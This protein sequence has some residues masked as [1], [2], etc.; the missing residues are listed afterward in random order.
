[1]A[2]SLKGF[3]YDVE[4]KK[5]FKILPHHQAPSGVKYS[6]EALKQD[7]KLKKVVSGSFYCDRPAQRCRA[8]GILRYSSCT[9]F[10]NFDHPIVVYT[11]SDASLAHYLVAPLPISSKFIHYAVILLDI[12]IS[13]TLL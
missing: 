8:F 12:N 7:T 6:K 13:F 5:Y 9:F 4:K 3:Y 1:M 10:S 2:V 11:N